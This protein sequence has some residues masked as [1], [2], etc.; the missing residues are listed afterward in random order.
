MPPKNLSL[1][2]GCDEK[3]LSLI[4]KLFYSNRTYYMVKNLNNKNILM[5]PSRMFT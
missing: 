3:L 5:T 2:K 1:E 4:N